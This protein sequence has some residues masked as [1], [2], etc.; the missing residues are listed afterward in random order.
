[1]KTT[2][3]VVLTAATLVALSC[4]QIAGFDDVEL[5]PSTGSGGRAI[6]STTTAGGAPQ[7]PGGMGGGG[8]TA[9]GGGGGGGAAGGAEG[10]G[11]SGSCDSIDIDPLNCGVCGHS[12]QG[13]ACEQGLCRPLQL[14]TSLGLPFGIAVDPGKD[15]EV[16]WTDAYHVSKTSKDGG[17]TDW[18]TETGD[19]YATG[20]AIDA[21]HV[22]FAILYNDAELYVARVDRAGNG[23]VEHLS[24]NWRAPFAIAIDD[25]H[26]YWTNLYDADGVVQAPLAGGLET[27]LYNNGLVEPTWEEPRGIAVDATHVYFTIQGSTTTGG[28]FQAPKGGGPVIQLATA[29]GTPADVGSA[30]VQVDDAYIYWFDGA[31]GGTLRRMSKD[32]TEPVMALAEGTWS[33]CLAQDATY[34][35]WTVHADPGEV[36]RVPKK[37][38]PVEV[39]ADGQGYPVGIAVDTTS[40]YW[41]NDHDLTVMK[42]AL[43][44]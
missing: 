44:P 28:L 20:V 33:E 26:V 21:S 23:P 27:V 38:G 14:G 30:G 42:L 43:P 39:L 3:R 35:Y 9:A 17:A 32:G 6:S 29:P 34:V 19:G 25:E 37:G 4:R 2:T 1:M 12:C 18:L 16:F 8:D 24:S 15:G 5:D 7:G 11:G 36:R 40:V 13:G 31:D 10:G 22:Y 41:L